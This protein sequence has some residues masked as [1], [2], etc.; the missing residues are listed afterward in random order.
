MICLQRF[1]CQPN[2]MV[3]KEWKKSMLLT[4]IH[5]LITSKILIYILEL[6]K[7]FVR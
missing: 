1:I 7:V 4:H 3:D 5:H 2:V 6:V